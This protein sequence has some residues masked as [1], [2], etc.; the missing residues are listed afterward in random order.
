[1]N[2][3]LKLIERQIAMSDLQRKSGDAIDQPGRFHDT[4]G[5]GFGPCLLISRE[6]GGGGALLGKAIG[7]RLGWGVFDS[8]LVD[9]I[10]NAAHVH[11]HLV[12]S[13][14][15]HTHSYLEKTLRDVWVGEIADERYMR[16]LKEVVIALGHHGNVVLVGRGAQFLLSPECALSV[17]L[18]A[19]PDTRMKRLA[20]REKISLQQAGKKAKQVDSDRAM[21]V[22]KNFNKDVTSALNHDLTIN[23]GRVNLND[24][25][26]I[27]LAALH[28]KFGVTPRGFGNDWRDH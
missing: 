3:V 21:F 28:G 13:V 12:R 20:E 26:E 17:R 27:V 14:D 25:A 19:P 24:A 7:D 10:A 1:M 16:H 5:V 23:T 11:Q 8:K 18:V 15:E 6:C 9:E 4:D 22:L 2:P